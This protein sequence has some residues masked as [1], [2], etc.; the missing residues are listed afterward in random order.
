GN[1]GCILG[2]KN[3][4]AGIDAMAYDWRGP[5]ADRM[6]LATAEGGRAVTDAV[7]ETDEVVAIARALAGEPDDRPKDG[8]RFHSS[9]PGS[10]QGFQTS[11][12]GATINNEERDGT[13]ALV[14]RCAGAATAT[15]PTFIPEEAIA[16]PGYT[17][18]A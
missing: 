12:E 15:T 1:L 10:V 4:L 17:L 13:R 14:L 3:G 6:Y 8:A 9:L 11:C 7:R 18:L 16:M 2:I 5:V